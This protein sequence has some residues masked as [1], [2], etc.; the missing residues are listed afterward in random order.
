MIA[1]IITIASVT[2]LVALAPTALAGSE[3]TSSHI[4]SAHIKNGTIQLVDISARA[5]R[6]LRGQRG[7]RGVP[8]APGPVGAQGPAGPQ[9]FAGPQGPQ[10]GPGLTGVQYVVTES[11]TSPAFATCPAGKFVIGG[12]GAAIGPTNL[13]FATAPNAANQWGA[14]ADPA[15]EPVVAFAVC[16]N[17]SA[18]PTSP[19]ALQ[20]ARAALEGK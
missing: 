5:R 19:A 13:L 6:A 15:G 12:G 7:L 11:A 2:F 18:P 14:A 1:K 16:A 20:A 10:G 9:G 3:R 17:L 8:G 4:T